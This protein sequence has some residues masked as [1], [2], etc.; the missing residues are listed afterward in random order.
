MST[1]QYD[2]LFFNYIEDGSTRSAC[3]ILP[4]LRDRLGPTTVLDVGCGR[5]AWSAQWIA[6]G[7][8]AVQGI[9]GDYVKADSLL[10]PQDQFLARDLSKPFD[11]GRRFDLV[12][13]LEVAEHISEQFAEIFVD[14]LCRH[15][16]IVFFSAAQPG[17]GGEFHVNE[18]P[19]RYW[20]EKFATHGYVPFDVVRPKF[21]SDPTVEPW[22]RY[23]SLI[24]VSQ[25]KKAFVENSFGTKAL[26]DSNKITSYEDI[27]WKIRRL[28]L[29]LIPNS[30]VTHLSKAY[31][32]IKISK[33]A[34]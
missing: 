8:G 3:A 17:Q 5:G 14:N 33:S 28:L 26:A 27:S 6:L 24:Y 32:Q 13:C 21:S 11:L 23:N 34:G 1:H 22:Y 2:Q 18:Q 4:F 15:G 25:E 10:I 29:G 31:H 16:D 19:L 12:Q 30:W 9:D 7:V 20:R